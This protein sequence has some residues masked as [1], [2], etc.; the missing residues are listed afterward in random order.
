MMAIR[1]NVEAVRELLLLVC[2]LVMIGAGLGLLQVDYPG[3]WLALGCVPAV[4]VSS[5]R[6]EGVGERELARMLRFTLAAF[7][8][9]VIG[10][11]IR[12]VFCA[13]LSCV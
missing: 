1:L 6:L 9:G 7:V 10:A 5:Y 2:V 13:V 8:G 12:W 4:V 11:N 3:L